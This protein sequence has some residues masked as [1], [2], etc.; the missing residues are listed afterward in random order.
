MMNIMD[1]HAVYRLRRWRLAVYPAIWLGV[2][3]WFAVIG[4]D[5]V[6]LGVFAPCARTTRLNPAFACS[7]MMLNR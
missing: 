3:V 5:S 1:E 4:A 6:R 7:C 2:A